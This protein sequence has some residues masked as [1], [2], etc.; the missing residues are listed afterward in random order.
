MKK[1]RD[2]EGKKVVEV[3]DLSY[4]TDRNHRYNWFQRHFYHH[5]LRRA[6]KKA[7]KII[8]ADKTVAYDIHRFYFIPINRIFLK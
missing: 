1:Y 5:R 6:L 7:S 2:T 8:A 3:S 4:L